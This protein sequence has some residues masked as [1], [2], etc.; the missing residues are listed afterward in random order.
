MNL[1]H[2]LGKKNVVVFFFVLASFY[3]IGSSYVGLNGNQVWRQSDSYSQILGFMGLKEIQP[4]SNFFGRVALY[5]MPIYQFLAAK[6]AVLTNT[7]PLVITKYLNLLFWF[8]LSHSG[9][10]IAERFCKNA[11][12]IFLSLI[13]TS[14]LLLHYFSTPLPDVMALA[15]SL[16]GIILLMTRSDWVGLVSGSILLLVSALI[17]SP[18]PFVFIIF[19][20][21]SLLSNYKPAEHRLLYLKNLLP[22]SLAFIAAVSAEQIRKYTIGVDLSGFANKPTWYF[23]TASQRLSSDFWLMI[24]HR[25]VYSFPFSKIGYIY[26]LM[27]VTYTVFSFR[28]SARDTLPFIVAFFAGWLIFSNLYF[29]HDY[30]ELPVTILFYLGTSFAFQKTAEKITGLFP[31]SEEFNRILLLLPS[32]IFLVMSP[33]EMIFMHNKISNFTTTS[34]YDSI[35]YAMRHTGEFIY[36]NDDR[37]RD[38]PDPSIGGLT[39]TRFMRIS[40][41]YL[42]KNCEQVLKDNSSILVNGSSECLNAHKGDATTYIEDDGLQF[43]FKRGAGPD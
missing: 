7:D 2:L 40:K 12:T 17:K 42:E 23:G 1:E 38:H 8:V 10:L 11:G 39:K 3:I 19:Y 27:F 5:D 36:V 28:T 9:Y 13:T 31:C 14:P 20:C 22:L 15:L 4:L 26:V 18:I 41:D 16:A 24:L 35:S 34:I 6:I 21:T 25:L 29:V 37:Y 30:Y 43:Y 33:I 32:L